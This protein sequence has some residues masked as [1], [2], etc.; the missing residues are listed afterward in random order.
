MLLG[1]HLGVWDLREVPI[2]CEQILLE[3]VSS[4]DGSFDYQFSQSYNTQFLEGNGMMN[5]EACVNALLRWESHS[6]EMGDKS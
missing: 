2:E 4:G 5:G 1:T 6:Q 3:L